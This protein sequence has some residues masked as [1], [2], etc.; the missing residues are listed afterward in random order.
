MTKS[1]FTT[2]GVACTA[3]RSISRICPTRVVREGG[4]FLVRRPSSLSDLSSPFLLLDEFGPVTYGPREAKGAPWH[5]HRGF[6]VRLF[7]VV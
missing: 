7:S 6:E 3:Y 2:A 4:G 5:P 1:S